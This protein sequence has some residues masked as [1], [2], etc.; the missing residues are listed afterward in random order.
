VPL[1]IATDEEGG[2]VQRLAAFG[3]LP[4]AADVPATMNPD[5]AEAMIARHA[6]TLRTLG[7]D[8]VFAPVVDV[9][10]PGGGGPIGD[11]SFG[12]DPAVV[13]TYAAA[14]VRGWTGAG[15]TPV[16]KHF[17]GHGA[18]TGDTHDGGAVV[19]PLDQ[20]RTRD[21]LPYGQLRDLGAGVMVGHLSVPG[22]TDADAVPASLSAAAYTLLRAEYADSAALLFTDA[23]GMNAVS[24]RFTLPDAATRSIR[25]GADVVIFTDTDATPAVLTRLG[26]AVADGSLPRDRVVDAA[27]RVLARKGVDPCM[28]A[29]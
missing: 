27:A 10:P 5:Q 16:L 21:L 15:V 13:A 29:G 20:L 11:R 28:T 2:G 24:D 19:A 26:N 25:A 9:L 3:T 1:L 17:P 23:L 14:Y 18:A 22:L 7:V 6:A 4:A 8:I 12:A